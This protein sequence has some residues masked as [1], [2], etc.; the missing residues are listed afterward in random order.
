MNTLYMFV[1]SWCPYC[2]KALSWMKELEAE[3][4]AYKDINI[5]IVDEEEETEIARKFDYY[6][7]PTYFLNEEKLFEGV[8]TKEIIKGVYDKSLNIQK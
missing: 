8:P 4:P 6:Y 7:V 3:N 2:K 5:K 1:T